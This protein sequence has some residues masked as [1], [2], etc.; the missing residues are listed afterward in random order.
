MVTLINIRIGSLR[1]KKTL[2]YANI[3]LDY[4]CIY[5]SSRFLIT[6]SMTRLDF[7]IKNY[8]LVIFCSISFYVQSTSVAM[9]SRE[10]IFF[11]LWLWLEVT[12]F[13]LSFFGNTLIILVM[14]RSKKLMIRSRYHIISIAVSDFLLGLFS[15][16]FAVIRGIQYQ[17]H[18]FQVSEKGCHFLTTSMLI[19]ISSLISQLVTV[20]IDRYWAICHPVS[21]RNKS[22]NCTKASIAICWLVGICFGILPLIFL[23][24]QCEC[25]FYTVSRRVEVS[26][27]QTL[28][29]VIIVAAFAMVILYC[30]IHKGLKNQVEKIC[31]A[32]VIFIR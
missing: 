3:H 17:N 12:A 21:Y 16:T 23:P 32:F 19:V 27:F 29:F 14:V 22:A 30:C 6:S 7:S 18:N 24:K 2:N 5:S 31:L 25:Q 8:H 4:K 20:S 11:V 9:L 15:I 26:Y 10:D 28:A 1:I 13:I